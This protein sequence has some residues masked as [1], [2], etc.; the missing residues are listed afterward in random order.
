MEDELPERRLLGA[1]LPRELSARF[2]GEMHVR[3]RL[4]CANV[5]IVADPTRDEG[6]D[7]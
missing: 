3:I 4:A 1:R 6:H 2:D 7:G 5:V